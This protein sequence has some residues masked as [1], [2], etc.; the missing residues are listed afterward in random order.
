M[1]NIILLLSATCT[2]F[3]FSCKK[4]RFTQVLEVDLPEHQSILAVTSHL[5]TQDTTLLSWVSSTLG[6]LEGENFGVYPD[7]QVQLFKNGN[8]IQNFNF[9]SDTKYHEIPN[10]MGLE[11]TDLATYTME[12]EVDGFDKVTASQKMPF[13]VAVSNATYT[14]LGT[15]NEEA[16]ERDEIIIKWNDPSGEENFYMFRAWGELKY[17]DG[18]T[19]IYYPGMVYLDSLDPLIEF[20]PDYELLINDSS[21]DGKEKQVIFYTEELFFEDQL[22]TLDK[23]WVELI[24]ISKDKYLYLKSLSAF[25]DARDN[26]FAEPVTV[27]NNF[28]NGTGIFTLE[29]TS[30][31][32][33]EL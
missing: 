25:F 10:F 32:D 14:P 6:A 29:S 20:G 30:R 24:S 4:D 17:N 12:V 27:H 7:A 19:I 23:L 5:S 28:E 22:F 26:P 11:A 21:F 9:N 31:F 13:P 15:I 1:K 18:D 2:L 3:L 8:L 16:E 33:I